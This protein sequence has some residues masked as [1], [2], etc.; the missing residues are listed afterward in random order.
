MA[1]HHLKPLKKNNT[2]TIKSPPQNSN[3]CWNQAKAYGQQ[4]CN[5]LYSGYA[6]AQE[7]KKSIACLGLLL[8]A[9]EINK[10][11]KSLKCSKEEQE[12]LC[13]NKVSES[14]SCEKKSS[15]KSDPC[16]K[17]SS[18]KSNPPCEQK[19]SNKSDPCIESPSSDDG[20]EKSCSKSTSISDKSSSCS[21][22]STSNSESKTS[23][24]K[25]SS[26][27]SSSNYTYG[28]SK[29]IIFIIDENQ[30]I[31]NLVQDQKS[32]QANQQSQKKVL[33][34]KNIK[35]LSSLLPGKVCNQI[36]SEL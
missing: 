22:D 3:G 27:S 34:V 17:K 13:D 30:D 6:C 2:I 26:S 7:Y 16:E 15:K 5:H 35:D 28:E 10:F 31:Q 4:C 11:V 24:S 8:G 9:Y 20:E 25:S 33:A 14:S 32:Q 1:K 18:N 21:I 23:S 29:N 19:S 36:L 12:I